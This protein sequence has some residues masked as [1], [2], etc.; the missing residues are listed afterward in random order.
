[1]NLF[2]PFELVVVI[3]FWLWWAPNDIYLAQ[4]CVDICRLKKI[5]FVISAFTNIP[6]Y[7]SNFQLFLLE[8]NWR[9]VLKMISFCSLGIVQ[10]IQIE[11]AWLMQRNPV[12]STSACQNIPRWVSSVFFI[13]LVLAITENYLIQ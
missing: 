12:P 4:F 11:M 1:M 7:V 13:S 10:L 9:H 5:L 2:F 8:I 6:I 3:S